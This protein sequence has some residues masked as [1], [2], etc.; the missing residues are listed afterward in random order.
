MMQQFLDS[1]LAN[2]DK[3]TIRIQGVKSMK[4]REGT[5]KRL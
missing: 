1:A 5:L 4:Y 2:D 3:D